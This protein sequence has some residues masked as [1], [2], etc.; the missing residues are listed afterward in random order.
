MSFEKKLTRR[1][2][3]FKNKTSQDQSRQRRSNL[4]HQLSNDKR[5]EQLK[6]KRA[7]NDS[8]TEQK[9]TTN[10]NNQLYIPTIEELPELIKGIKSTNIDKVETSIRGIRA[11]I[12]VEDNPPIDEIIET[13]IL[14]I[15]VEFLDNW[16][17]EYI[18]FEAE[19]IITNTCSG[20][21]EQA[22]YCV[23]LDIIPKF[24]SLL[25]SKNEEVLE[26]VGLEWL[27]HFNDVHS[28]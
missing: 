28:K 16:D 12:S 26:Q 5:Q 9:Q 1:K 6:K 20:T 15:V 7:I 27:Y 2:K 21:H 3:L 4:L 25:S 24:V 14:E 19:W 11:M 10:N 22:Q 17:N 13:G 18:Q 8:Q 23:D